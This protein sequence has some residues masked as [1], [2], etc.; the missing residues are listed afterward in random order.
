MLG[1]GHLQQ[2][3]LQSFLSRQAGSGNVRIWLAVDGRRRAQMAYSR[4]PGCHCFAWMPYA[5]S[6]GRRLLHADHIRPYSDPICGIPA[7]FG[8]TTT[9]VKI[10]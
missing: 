8:S 2:A 4:L 9:P 5:Y 10:N 3:I 6:P 7:A 1:D